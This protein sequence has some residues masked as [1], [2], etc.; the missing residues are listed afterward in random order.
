M[1][2]ST[3]PYQKCDQGINKGDRHTAGDYAACQLVVVSN[4]ISFQRGYG[5]YNLTGLMAMD[6]V[7]QEMRQV[8]QPNVRAD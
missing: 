8:V 2:L 5:L 4:Q 7:W 3:S 6:R 1:L